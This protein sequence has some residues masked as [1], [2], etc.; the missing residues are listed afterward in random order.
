MLHR[1]S[2]ET[3]VEGF[4]HDGSL[5]YPF[6]GNL[7]S[8]VSHVHAWS[9]GP[10]TSLMSSTIGLSNIT[11]IHKDWVFS[12]AIIDSQLEYASGGFNVPNV[13]DFAAS[14]TLSPNGN[15]YDAIVQ[16]PS[17]TRSTLKLELPPA[18]NGS[19]S[20]VIVSLNDEIVFEQGKSIKKANQEGHFDE[21]TKLII[22]PGITMNKQQQLLINVS[23][24]QSGNFSARASDPSPG[25]NVTDSSSFARRWLKASWGTT[26]EIF[27]EI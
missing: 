14:W 10:I 13:G 24:F 22:L 4:Y 21:N 5:H 2:N 16:A 12:P 11:S 26:V 9:T 6:Y 20:S 3:L 18:A 23:A 27:N 15:S 17:S 19:V 25:R 8:Y 1:F 7:D